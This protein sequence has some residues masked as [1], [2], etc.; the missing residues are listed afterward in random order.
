MMPERRRCAQAFRSPTRSPALLPLLRSRRL[1]WTSARRDAAGASMYRFRS[2]AA[3]HGWVVSNYLNGNVAPEPMGNENFTAAPS[4]TFETASGPPSIAA[5]EQKQYETLCDLVG[6]PELKT[7]PR[8]GERQSRKTYRAALK[9]ELELALKAKPA[10]DWEAIFN[11]AGVPSGCVLDG[12]RY[13][14]GTT[15]DRTQVR[16]DA[17]RDGDGHPAHARHA[18]GISARRRVSNPIRH[19]SSATTQSGGWQP[20]AM[21]QTRSTRCGRAALSPPTTSRP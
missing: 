13:P 7:D 17:G 19:R 16:R 11:A 15:A 14:D 8:F 5:N 2:D 3:G 21:A 4:G 20:L 12:A 6:R 9:T 18:P 1:S 10:T